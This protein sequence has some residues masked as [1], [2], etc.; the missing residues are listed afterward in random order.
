MRRPW[1]STLLLVLY[2][3]AVHGL[4]A[5]HLGWHK[6]D[7]VHELGGLRWLPA[8]HHAHPHVLSS[9]HTD[10]LYEVHADE[11]ASW[12]RL[13]PVEGASSP[14]LA[15]HLSIGPS[16][17]QQ[18]LLAPVAL[19]FLALARPARPLVATQL[20]PSL[21]DVRAKPRARAPPASV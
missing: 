15:L 12:P 10:H 18:S 21:R 11:R 7:H 14:G 16:H 19:V 4:P 17:G 9:P 5:L 8:R 3:A 2:V 1:L 6:N 20:F 13:R